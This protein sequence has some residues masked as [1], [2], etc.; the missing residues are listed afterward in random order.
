MKIITNTTYPSLSSQPAKDQEPTIRSPDYDS[1]SVSDSESDDSLPECNVNDTLSDEELLPPTS[2]LEYAM[3]DIDHVLKCLY[4]FST[5]LYQ[6]VPANRIQKC[7]SID[8]KHYEFWDIQHAAN[9]LELPHAPKVLQQ[10]LGRAN[11]KRRQLLIYN[12]R[13]HKKISQFID[14]ALDLEVL[15][16]AGKTQEGAGELDG[17]Q[18]NTSSVP[19]NEQVPIEPARVRA[20]GTV[21]SATTATT[22]HANNKTAS[23]LEPLPENPGQE[24]DT[25]TEKP[26]TSYASSCASYQGLDGYKLFVPDPPHTEEDGFDDEPFLCPYCHDMVCIKNSKSWT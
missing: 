24:S 13:H 8:V 12:E 2:D 15:E 5:V 21:L 14:A 18:P 10:R 22:F 1:L 25:D 26:Q 3:L 7:A 23:K 11:T 19:E 16:P 17:T 9:K 6:A 20:P 4:R